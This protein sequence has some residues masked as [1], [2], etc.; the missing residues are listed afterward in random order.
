MYILPLYEQSA[1]SFIVNDTHKH[2][3]LYLWDLNSIVLFLLIK[4][5][6]TKNF[7]PC[8]DPSKWKVVMIEK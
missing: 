3:L 1:F 8:P 5:S 4:N 6:V 2:W 7:L